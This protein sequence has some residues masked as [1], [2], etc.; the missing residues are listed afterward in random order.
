MP[1]TRRM[2]R[3]STLWGAVCIFLVQPALAQLETK[4]TPALPAL[5]SDSPAESQ[6]TQDTSPTLC[7]PPPR[8]SDSRLLGPKVCWTQR[9]W[10]GLHAK[11]LD[12][13]ADGKSIVASEKYRSLNPSAC[14]SAVGCN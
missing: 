13:G 11:G 8:Q 14:G 9:Q 6:V 12:I 4:V 5:P 2:P 3:R 1:P 10:D 7:R